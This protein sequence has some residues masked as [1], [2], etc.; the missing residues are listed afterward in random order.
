MSLPSTS[1]SVVI[2]CFNRER[3]VAQTVRSVL[4]QSYTDVKVVVVDDGSTDRSMKVVESLM[5]E[6]PDRLFL[7]Q[8]PDRG[9]HGQSAAIN[10]GL[11]V[12]DSRYIAIIDSDD[13]WLP[14]KLETQVQVLEAE[15]GIGVVYSNGWA[16]DSEGRQLYDL[17]PADHIETNACGALLLNCYLQLPS[18]ALIRG[19]A[20]RKAGLFDETLRAAQD[21]DMAIRLAE[22]TRFEYV[23]R[24]LYCYR[25]H[26]ASISRT[27]AMR[28]WRNGFKILEAAARRHTYPREIVRHRR[29]VLHFRLAQ[30]L[31]EERAFA[32]ALFHLFRSAVS[33][34]TRAFRVLMRR[35]RITSPH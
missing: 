7:L 21:H 18:N 33:H 28:R 20:L 3:Y 10:V 31:L 1:V 19:T 2:P 4:D 6:Y 24:F 15:P 16:V 22:V 5:P 32:E 26:A 27:G 29:A 11:R 14:G 17:F 34:P 12:C 25:R 9:N 8:H 30:V 23:P 35:E 13:Y